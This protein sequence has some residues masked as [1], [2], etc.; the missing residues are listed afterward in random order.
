LFDQGLAARQVDGHRELECRILAGCILLAS[1]TT[2][3]GE[4][5]EC[6]VLVNTILGKNMSFLMRRREPLRC[7]LVTLAP[8][9]ANQRYARQQHRQLG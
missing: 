6:R 9:H 4:Y 3:A 2:H 5:S 7:P 8:L 1:C